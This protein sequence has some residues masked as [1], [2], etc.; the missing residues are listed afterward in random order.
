ML[1]H[2]RANAR[3]TLISNTTIH[4]RSDASSAQKC[5]ADDCQFAR[6]DCAAGVFITRTF[7]D[8]RAVNVIRLVESG[9]RRVAWTLS[10]GFWQEKNFSSRPA[11]R[12][13]IAR[14]NRSFGR[15]AAADSQGA[16][17][18]V[19]RCIATFMVNDRCT[20]R[21]LG[22]DGDDVTSRDVQ[23]P[24]LDLSSSFTD[25]GLALPPDDFIT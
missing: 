5:D 15:I 24:S 7:G 4:P 17:F 10:L 21:A 18:H 20:T 19:A 25:C 2:P 22:D 23:R 11:L 8:R 1:T 6:S 14:Q 3:C 13:F 9:R 12:L 16:V